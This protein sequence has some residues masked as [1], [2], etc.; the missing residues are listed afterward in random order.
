[1][2]GIAGIFTFKKNLDI[3]SNINLMATNMSHRGP[4]DEGFVFFTDDKDRFFVFGGN[5]TP[6]SVYQNK[7]LF[8]PK[9]KYKGNIPKNSFLAFAHRR[10]AIQDLSSAGHQP[11]STEDGRFWIT[12]NGEIYNF[13]EIR[14][15]L[16]YEGEV[17]F[18]NSDTE[19]ILKAYRRW[20]I[21]CLE[22]FNGMWAF[23]IWDT[24]KKE[25][26][27]CRDRIGIKPFYYYLTRDFFVFASEIRGIITTN[28]YNP[29]PD[30]HA[31]YHAMSFCVAPRPTTCFRDIR[32]LEQAHWM[33]IDCSGK[34]RKA[35]F[36]APPLGKIDKSKSEKDWIVFI[37]EHIKNAVKR[38]LIADVPV[39]TFM[40]GGVDSTTMSALAS[41]QSD[42][43]TA[44]TLGFQDKVEEVDELE[45]ARAV[46]LRYPNII[47]REV[48][49]KAEI[50]LT[51]IK[52]ITRCNEEPFLTLDPTYILSKA[53][54]EM[55]IK[56]VLNGLGADELFF[57]YGH[58]KIVRCWQY[59]RFIRNIFALLSNFECQYSKYFYYFSSSNVIECYIKIFSIFREEEKKK[60][61]LCTEAKSYNSYKYFS[62]LYQLDSL[63][64]T[65]NF[66]CLTYLE[67]LDYIGNYHVFRNDQF[68]MLFSLETRFPYLDHKLVEAVF[69]MPS[70]LKIKEKQNKYILRKIAKKYIP[71]ECLEMRKKGFGM[72]MDFWMSSKI[73]S[74]VEAKI[75]SLKDRG[76][77]NAKAI[78]DI[79]TRF[80][81]N[82]DDYKKLWYLVSI[83]LWLEEF[84][85]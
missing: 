77:F 40:S 52:E 82:K 72:P 29:Q 81:Q 5:D 12:Y 68:S 51:K 21:D 71:G 9:K 36:W 31:L 34:V 18:S 22:M 24:V 73:K 83:E 27:C 54:H 19:V 48:I 78:D 4:D 80:Y 43:I 47:H 25:L 55:G 41:L 79:L 58:Q 33:K 66:E 17:F 14:K 57:G 65:D 64:F 70:S 63:E 45:Q 76:I 50:V 8:S 62:Q 49:T 60:L 84:F 44:F 11:M 23:V 74:F 28:L 20:G 26:L 35:R 42:M 85:T 16:E 38:R 7:L 59:L 61:F 37:E 3:L 32:S 75:A 2:C 53:L 67:L 15:K 69:Q 46:A 56:V 30:W 39:A 6:E 10:L 1:M 13:K